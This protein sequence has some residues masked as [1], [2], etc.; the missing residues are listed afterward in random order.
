M[1][2]KSGVTLIRTRFGLPIVDQAAAERFAVLRASARACAQELLVGLGPGMIALVIGPSGSG[3]SMILH[4]LARAA[5]TCVIARPVSTQSRTPVIDRL[6][7]PIEQRLCRLS[8]CGLADAHPLVTPAGK[9]SDGQKARLS[10]AIA[11]EK[12]SRTRSSTVLVDEFC[13]TLDRTAAA[14][15]A[16]SVRRSIPSETAIVCAT[17]HDDLIEH[18]RPDI[19]VYVPLEG[20][21]EMLSREDA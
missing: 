6:R 2:R 18:L 9:L 1:N 5:P 20:K 15:V 16:M 4:E 7:A 21:P 14:S 12:A 11:I 13:S 10:L 17:A 3:K 8:A 19:L